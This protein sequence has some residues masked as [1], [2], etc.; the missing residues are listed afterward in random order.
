[1][2]RKESMEA[3][4]ENSKV[5]IYDDTCPLC[6]WYTAQFISAGL[7]ARDGRQSFTDLSSSKL[8]LQLDAERSRHEIPLVDR[9]GGEVLYGLDSLLYILGSRF[10]L[11]EKIAR[12]SPMHAFLKRFYGFVSYNRRIIVPS[13]QEQVPDF[14]CSPRFH[15]GYRTAFLTFCILT[16]CLITALLGYSTTLEGWS[17]L[18]RC[19]IALLGCGT[20]WAIMMLS[21]FRLKKE[22]KW[23]YWGQ[24][25][26]IMLLGV[27]ALVP[28][29]LLASLFSFGN[30]AL[31]MSVLCSAT[32]MLREHH[33]RVELIGIGQA[34]T[35]AWMMSLAISAI[36]FVLLGIN[37]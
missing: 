3:M 28:G 17:V 11:L 6:N 18:K 10:P 35:A 12:W 21:A 37:F 1:M 32:L 22:E 13:K 9:N 31:A 20:G 29:I 27:L 15:L 33:R 25:A 8:G 34:W 23:D 2:G 30:I 19:S 24:L 7:L 36:S 26:V 4:T 14:D 5:I 16:A